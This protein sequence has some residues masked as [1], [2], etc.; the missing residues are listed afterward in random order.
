M[1]DDAVR[2]GQAAMW[3]LGHCGWALR[4]ESHFLFV[5]AS[6]RLAE[7]GI[8]S[9]RFDFRGS[10][11]SEGEF[12]RAVLAGNRHRPVLVRLCFDPYLRALAWL[13][14]SWLRR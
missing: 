9:L 14:G 2:D 3:Y 13:V 1:L 11:E 6:R 7:R 12:H 8:A 4:T 10:G 5:A